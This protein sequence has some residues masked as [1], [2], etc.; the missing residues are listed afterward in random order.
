M[1]AARWCHD[2]I[3]SAVSVAVA[4]DASRNRMH[5]CT[6]F[7]PHAFHVFEK[8]TR[9]RPQVIDHAGL[10]KRVDR[11]CEREDA[12]EVDIRRRAVTAAV[13][14]GRSRRSAPRDMRGRGRGPRVVDDR[15]RLTPA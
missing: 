14:V 4:S 15:A 1:R 11:S 3:S 6:C 7:G 8:L 10:G 9:G 12:G 5:V 13:V 2:S